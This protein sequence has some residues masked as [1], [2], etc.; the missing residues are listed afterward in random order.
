MTITSLVIKSDTLM[1]IIS[2]IFFYAIYLNKCKFFKLHIILQNCFYRPSSYKNVMIVFS[3][4]I[5]HST[6]LAFM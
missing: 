2:V 4:V 5:K 1:Y 6:Q 3:L